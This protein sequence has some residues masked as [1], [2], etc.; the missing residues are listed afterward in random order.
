MSI[1]INQA[2]Y[3]RSMCVVRVVSE[4]RRRA[5]LVSA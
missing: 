4:D 1:Y 2:W 5:V 3:E